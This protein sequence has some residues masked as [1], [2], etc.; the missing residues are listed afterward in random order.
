MYPMFDKPLVAVPAR[1]IKNKIAEFEMIIEYLQRELDGRVIFEDGR[2]SFKFGYAT[3]GGF[4]GFDTFDEA[5]ENIKNDPWYARI[6]EE[7]R[8]YRIHKV[9]V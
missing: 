1:V 3:N 4:A 7:D 6:P 9:F 8:M 2:E 5:A